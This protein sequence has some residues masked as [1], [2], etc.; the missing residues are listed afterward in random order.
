MPA[1][2]SARKVKSLGL[3]LV[4]PLLQLTLIT[5]FLVYFGL[6][7]M[8]KFMERKVMV[9]ESKREVEGIPAPTI[10]VNARNLTTR[11]GWKGK[12]NCF[13]LPI[14]ESLESCIKEETFG[15]TDVVEDVILGYTAKRSLVQ[16]ESLT[17]SESVT[18]WGGKYFKLLPAE[19]LGPNYHDQ[20]LLLS[21]YHGF[22]YK[23]FISDPNYFVLTSNPV[24]LPT[25][26]KTVN[27][28]SSAIG[29]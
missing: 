23:L 27:P 2:F 12:K 29:H 5:I 18:S 6:P 3:Q 22:I 7:A 11:R 16:S 13:N 15:F 14:E 20:M 21:L 4:R 24:Y 26:M 10:T 17:V 8:G 28:N 1:K 9:V 19:V 25:I